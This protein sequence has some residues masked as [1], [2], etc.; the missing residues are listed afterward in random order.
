MPS[1]V[2]GYVASL[3]ME[4]P[5]Q[6]CV[7]PG[8]LKFDD[9]I[10]LKTNIENI[11]LSSVIG[12]NDAKEMLERRLKIYLEFKNKMTST[13]SKGIMLYGYPGTGKTMLV[14]AV[15]N[16]M[17]NK[18][19][20]RVIVTE[21]DLTSHSNDTTV[22]VINY[23]KKLRNHAKGR[24]ILL[25]MD[26][27]EGIIGIKGDHGILSDKR[28]AQILREIDGITNNNKDIFILAT[29]N[30][31]SMIE[32]AMLRSGRIDYHIKV[33]MP[34]DHERYLMI[35]Q[36]SHKFIDEKYFSGILLGTP[37]WT[38]ANYAQLGSELEMEFLINNGGAVSNT[39]I[40]KLVEQINKYSK[41]N[42]KTFEKEYKEYVNRTE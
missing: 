34:D 17:D 20:L 18:K 4:I 15:M 26:E 40:F 2:S 21:S 36:Y 6:Y 25:L 19:V 23:F 28:V 37:N 10:I 35:K 33:E 32:P 31:P 11:K 5:P 3:N 1:Q 13:L 42:F 38:G 9:D 8:E 7:P 16:L 14:K 30:H 22:T 41:R 12:L 24:D 29:T 27:A 39:T